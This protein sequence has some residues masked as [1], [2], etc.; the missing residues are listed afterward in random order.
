MQKQNIDLKLSSD[1]F[2]N[3]N[4]KYF[5]KEKDLMKML[6]NLPGFNNEIKSIHQLINN[7]F[8][9]AI[10]YMSAAN[11]IEKSLEGLTR[12]L[13]YYYDLF[14]NI[15]STN[16][17]N[18]K[19]FN[20]Y[21]PHRYKK[22]FVTFQH[23]AHTI[24]YKN[25]CFL[26]SFFALLEFLVDNVQQD[27]LFIFLPQLCASALQ[28]NIN[29]YLYHNN[30]LML[31]KFT[32]K[33]DKYASD[34]LANSNKNPADQKVFECRRQYEKSLKLNNDDRTIFDILIYSDKDYKTLKYFALFKNEVCPDAGLL[35]ELYQEWDEYGKNTSTYRYE[36]FIR[37]SFGFINLVNLPKI[38]AS[39][40]YFYG[41][42]LFCS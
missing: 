24:I 32:N 33:I 19:L 13:A 23:A 1:Q 14:T 5:G 41:K 10:N 40:T 8:L 7:N 3:V 25:E 36:K 17:E 38:D 2:E 28:A 34:F 30:S 37:F 27:Q 42:L 31:L 12:R 20:D 15:Q 26:V 35:K 29:L 6:V 21:I 22:K 18:L 4:K 39:K 11:N 9:F 16:E